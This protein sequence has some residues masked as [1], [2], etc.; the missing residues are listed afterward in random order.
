M[1]AG[2]PSWWESHRGGG[3]AEHPQGSHAEGG[4]WDLAGERSLE[5]RS[6]TEE[7]GMS[8]YLGAGWG[9]HKQ[10]IALPRGSSGHAVEVGLSASAGAVQDRSAAWDGEQVLRFK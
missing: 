6:R 8:G 4:G 10:G 1:C 2:A 9:R 3:Q 7:V 5:S